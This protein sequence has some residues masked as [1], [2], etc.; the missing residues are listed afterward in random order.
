MRMF[1]GVPCLSKGQ[2]HPLDSLSWKLW[3]P[4]RHFSHLYP[5][6]QSPKNSSDSSSP[7]HSCGRCLSSESEHLKFNFTVFYSVLGSKFI[8][9][10]TLSSLVLA[11]FLPLPLYDHTSGMLIKITEPCTSSL[12]AN[13]LFHNFNWSFIQKKMLNK[14][15]SGSSNESAVLG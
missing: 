5:H 10:S 2:H 15:S 11:K 7:L 14:L 12:K 3:S 13:L 1:S 6:K 8:E 4:L 9:V